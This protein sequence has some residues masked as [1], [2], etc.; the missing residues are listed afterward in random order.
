MHKNWALFSV[1][2]FLL[3][4]GGLLPA[5][6]ETP[7]DRLAGIDGY[8][9][10]PRYSRDKCGAHFQWHEGTN[11]FSMQL[12]GG[13][14]P[15]SGRSVELYCGEGSSI[16]SSNRDP[17]EPLIYYSCRDQYGHRLG[18]DCENEDGSPMPTAEVSAHARIR[19]MS[20]SRRVTLTVDPYMADGQRTNEAAQQILLQRQEPQ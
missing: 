1:F 2:V 17:L 13:E 5:L 20:G 18:S 6:A 7:E 11:R 14:C 9:F 4:S 10:E 8:N 12:T 3:F 19:V 15:Q 16:C